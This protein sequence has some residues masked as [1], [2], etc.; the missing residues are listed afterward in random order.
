MM[1]TY[2][3]NINLINLT[4]KHL[5]WNPTCQFLVFTLPSSGGHQRFGAKHEKLCEV[6]GDHLRA[7]SQFAG[8]NMNE[9]VGPEKTS[10]VII[11][12]F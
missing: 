9:S 7:T 11:Y 1:Q 10:R 2:W 12:V 8:F 3:K 5:R 6:V 4:A